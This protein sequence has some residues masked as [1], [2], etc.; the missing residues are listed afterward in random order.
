MAP[1]V[2]AFLDGKGSWVAAR[3]ASFGAALGSA[4]AGAGGGGLG[5]GGTGSSLALRRVV[6]YQNGIGYF[7]RSGEVRQP[8]Y[9]LRLRSHEID[10]VLKSLVVISETG[11]GE[12]RPV[13]AVIPSCR[14]VGRQSR[15]ARRRGRE[16]MRPARLSTIAASS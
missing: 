5:C 7:E 10:D 11:G 15:P 14:P 13:T 1:T 2:P 8:V 9:R 3:A 6:L 12:V 16:R 4:R